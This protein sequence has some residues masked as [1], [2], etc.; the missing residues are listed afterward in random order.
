MKRAESRAFVIGFVLAIALAAGALQLDQGYDDI[1]T[2]LHDREAD[3]LT[4]IAL[5]SERRARA[6]QAEQLRLGRIGDSLS[7]VARVALAS[8]KPRDWSVS[9]GSV[10]PD[11]RLPVARDTTD[12]IN[13]AR[14]IDPQ[15]HRAPKFLMDELLA[16][17][18]RLLIVSAA[19][20]GERV[21]RLHAD[22]VTIPD[23]K[24]QLF[25]SDDRLRNAHQRIDDRDRTIARQGR[26]LA[27]RRRF[28]LKEGI[29]VGAGAATL[30]F[31]GAR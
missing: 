7:T 18:A 20:Q 25:D 21:A 10:A 31:L 29:V 5:A 14:P 6:S 27:I 19:W 4:K 24:R 17:D 15:P 11:S 8:A 9:S 2:A 28:G 22:S 26:E 16:I 12:Y 3:S 1:A 23:L 13:V 30:L